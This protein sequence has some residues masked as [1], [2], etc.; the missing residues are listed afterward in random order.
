VALVPPMPS[1]SG[2]R[3]YF[4]E[5]PRK[6]A[7]KRGPASKTLCEQPETIHAGLSVFSYHVLTLS[8]VLAERACFA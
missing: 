7:E 6:L 2:E 8:L 1:S 4:L 5:Q 3:V